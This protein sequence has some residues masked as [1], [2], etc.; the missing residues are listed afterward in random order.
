MRL[1]MNA[2]A[3]GS[4]CELRVGLDEVCPSVKVELALGRTRGAG[5]ERHRLARVAILREERKRDRDAKPR[6]HLVGHLE[7]VEPGNAMPHR[8]VLGLGRLLGQAD[9]ASAEDPPLG[10]V[11]QMTVVVGNRRAADIALLCPGSD[12]LGS[13]PSTQVVDWPFALGGLTPRSSPDP[14][15]NPRSPLTRSARLRL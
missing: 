9:L 11:E 15:R 1:T 14:A 7:V 4:S 5:I 6:P 3:S 10:Q 13:N 8:P 2:S 12:P